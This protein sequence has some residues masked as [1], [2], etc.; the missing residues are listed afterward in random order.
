MFDN[1][2]KSF[3]QWD[4]QDR[5]KIDAELENQAYIWL[6]NLYLS[7]ERGDTKL[8]ITTAN[9]LRILAGKSCPNDSIMQEYW[10]REFQKLKNWENV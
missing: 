5:A 8:T 4:K 6:N 7:I 9:Q 10:N 2:K 3:E 1:L